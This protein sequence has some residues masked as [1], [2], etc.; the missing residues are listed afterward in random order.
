[1]VIIISSFLLLFLIYIF[2][3][4]KLYTFLKLHFNLNYMYKNNNKIIIFITN[5][6]NTIYL[7]MF[8]YV[9][10]YLFVFI[11]KCTVF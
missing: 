9:F 5:S 1:M 7:Q 3:L 4:K 6:I 8:V 10:V 2:Y 11:Y